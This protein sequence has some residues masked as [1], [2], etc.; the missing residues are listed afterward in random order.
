MYS[1]CLFVLPFF[2]PA[3]DKCTKSDQYGICYIETHTDDP[4]LFHLSMDLTLTGGYSIKFCM[5]PIAVMSHDNY[6]NQ[7]YR[8]FVLSYN[9]RHIYMTHQLLLTSNRINHSNG[10][11]RMDRPTESHASKAFQYCC[12]KHSNGL[13]VT[14]VTKQLWPTILSL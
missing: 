11:L 1:Y 5:K 14:W 7:F 10:L 6:Y 4:K 13:L 3:F 12:I 2:S 8:H 9:N